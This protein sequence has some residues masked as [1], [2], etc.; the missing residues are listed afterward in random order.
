LYLRVREPKSKSLIILKVK[1]KENIRYKQLVG[2]QAKNEFKQITKY[3]KEIWIQLIIIHLKKMNFIVADSF[4]LPT[5]HISQINIFLKQ[6][7]KFIN[8]DSTV[9]VL[10]S[11][12]IFLFDYYGH[13]YIARLISE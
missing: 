2:A 3:T 12:P 1:A 13:E 4:S 11:F 10:S 5:Y 9:S 6:L 7:E 8:K